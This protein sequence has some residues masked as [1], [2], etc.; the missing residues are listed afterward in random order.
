MKIGATA[1]GNYNPFQ[2][3]N[4]APKPK[5]D[6][7]KEL[8]N[9]DQVINKDEKQFFTN[10]YPENKTEIIDYHF[11]QRSGKM[12]GVAVGINIDKRG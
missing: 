11:Y 8:N 4:V 6:F 2:V 12:S 5:V 10:L 3:K 7:S 9:T 1:A